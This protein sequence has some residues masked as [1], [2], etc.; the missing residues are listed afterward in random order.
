MKTRQASH[1][2]VDD[3]NLISDFLARRDAPELTAEA[4]GGA[5]DLI[6]FLGNSIP[7]T[8]AVVAKAIDVGIANRVLIAGGVGH[9]TKDLWENVR[10]IT[11]FSHIRTEGRPEA[12]VLSDILV[13]EYE[14]PREMILIENR[15]TNCGSNA[16]ETK[17]V[18]AETDLRPRRVLLIQDPTMQRRTHASFQRAWRG[19]DPIQFIS[20]APFIPF[21]ETEGNSGWSFS[22]LAWSQTR[23]ISLLL[24]EIPRLL[25]SPDGYG[26]LGKDFIEHVDVPTGVIEAH[27]RLATVYGS[28]LRTN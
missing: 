4:L 28:L 12:D 15:S 24:G 11:E 13:E 5:V 17:S 20:Y 14:I 7:A 18:L 8:S 6:V 1:Q 21:A 23:F 22:P 16:W 9:S 26:P 2:I 25:D 27:K 3:V 19:E 10:Q